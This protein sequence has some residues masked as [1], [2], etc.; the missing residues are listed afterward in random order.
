MSTETAFS[1]ES[2]EQAY[3]KCLRDATSLTDADLRQ[4][5]LIDR[6]FADRAR[7]TRAGFEQKLSE[8]DK[9]LVPVWV[10]HRVVNEFCMVPLKAE[11]RRREQLEAR[12]EELE[13]RPI[14]VGG[15]EYGGI[16]SPE[17][18]YA[19]STLVT[20][21]GGLWLSLRDTVNESPG[22]ST[23]WRLVVKS[24]GA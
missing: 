10:M 12:V 14:T 13:A 5:E 24:G 11:I 9:K 7:A 17:K 18:R 19:P 21:G 3:H 2:F 22:L 6:N 1:P 4:L 20:R 8:L 15:V 23:A 16:Y